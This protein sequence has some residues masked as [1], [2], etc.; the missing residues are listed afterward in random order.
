LF[1]GCAE[2]FSQNRVEARV[3]QAEFVI[4]NIA[5]LDQ[6]ADKWAEN[7]DG[8]QHRPGI[9][10]LFETAMGHGLLDGGEGLVGGGQMAS[11]MKSLKAVKGFALTGKGDK[12]ACEVGEIGP[13]VG[14]PALW[15]EAD[16]AFLGLAQDKLIEEIAAERGA[17][18]IAGAQDYGAHHSG[19]RGG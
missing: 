11:E 17:V 6:T 12:G 2:I 14:N 15:V 4:P 7:A 3:G 9:I 19:V 1:M 8:A 18:E 13:G 10:G 16:F 5:H